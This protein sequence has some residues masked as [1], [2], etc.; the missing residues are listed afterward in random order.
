MARNSEPGY[1]AAAS[2]SNAPAARPGWRRGVIASG[3]DHAAPA[4]AIEHG[5]RLAAARRRFPDAPEPF[6]DLSTGINPVAY[7]VPPLPATAFTRL[8]E[9]EELDMLQYAAARA[10]G[11][12][13]PAM[14]VAAPGTQ[15]LISLLPR[16]FPCRT[17][18]ILGPTYAEHAAAWRNAGSEVLLLPFLPGEAEAALVMCNPNNPDGHRTSI[19]RLLA[20]A[21]RQAACNGLL[22][23]DEAFADFEAGDS[24]APSLPLPG[25]I[26]LRSFGKAYGLAGLRLGFALASPE[27]AALIR[28]AL[29]PWAVSGPALHIG[30]TALRD[31]AWRDAAAARLRRDAAALDR[32]LAGAGMRV[33]G[34]TVLFRLAEATGAAGWAERLGR[35]GILVRSFADAPNRLRFGIPGDPAAWDRLAAALGV[36][37]VCGAVA[38]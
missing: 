20:L 13:D 11:A 34:G 29:G 7:P 26:V 36:G 14:V 32:L 22:V 25:V 35:A 8:P 3:L 24:L 5:G 19:Q 10:Y 28:T 16:L 9:P 18:T 6:I 12:A 30:A 21:R 1:P 4:E 15:V 31:T 33:V 17:A 27:R 37:L 38:P 2:T 23:V